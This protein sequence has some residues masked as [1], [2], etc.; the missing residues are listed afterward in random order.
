VS[1][2]GVDCE[3]PEPSADSLAQL[4]ERIIAE[5]TTGMFQ[6]L[7]ASC[8]ADRTLQAI[9]PY[10]MH[11]GLACASNARRRLGFKGNDLEAVAMPMY[12]AHAAISRGAQKEMEIREGGAVEEMY[13]CALMHAPPEI[14]VA[15]SHFVTE[16]MC[17]AVNPA[18]EYIWTH[19][20]TNGDGRCRYVVREKASTRPVED[21]GKLLR[22]IPK[23]E[24]TEEEKRVLADGILAEQ[25]NDFIKASL[26]LNGSELTVKIVAPYSMKTGVG[27]GSL[28]TPSSSDDR[29]P[30]QIALDAVSRCR[31]ALLQERTAKHTSLGM[32]GE[33]TSCPFE[34][35]PPELCAQI[36]GMLDAM[37]HT[38]CPGCSF[39]YETMRTK[40]DTTC[41]WTV[42][43]LKEKGLPAKAQQ[44]SQDPAKVLAMRLANGEISEEEFDRKIT[45]LKKHG[46]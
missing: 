41:R 13:Y 5:G 11:G 32:A 12:W 17:E 23:V 46:L 42:A 35:C 44:A 6:A 31:L 33:T 18:F 15:I 40:G 34:N 14:C 39:S 43:L 25:W 20:L 21:L 26:D 24:L 10:S 4:R 7:I 45:L 2:Q 9:K 38:I 1:Q 16:G 37:C 30:V 29:E 36:E 27:L 3:V 8:G 19:H 22:T 28:F